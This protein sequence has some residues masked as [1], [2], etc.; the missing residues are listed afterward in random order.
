M[1]VYIR[2]PAP[3]YTPHPKTERDAV[4][5][6]TSKTHHPIL[7]T[8]GEGLTDTAKLGTNE[9]RILAFGTEATVAGYSWE[10]SKPKDPTNHFSLTWRNKDS[11][12]LGEAE[13]T[14]RGPVS[15]SKAKMGG[16]ALRRGLC[17]EET[18][19]VTQELIIQTLTTVRPQCRQ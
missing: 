10:R 14:L 8:P 19:T 5:N 12:Q 16:W 3:R 7:R 2:A 17:T 13:C 15:R 11:W 4:Y 18:H 6:E 9:R 1:Q